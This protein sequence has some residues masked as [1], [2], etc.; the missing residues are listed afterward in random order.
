MPS[1][2]NGNVISNAALEAILEDVNLAMQQPRARDCGNIM[3]SVKQ[4]LNSHK[5]T[6]KQAFALQ[7]KREY[8][9]ERGFGFLETQTAPEAPKQEQPETEN[10]EP[11]P[12]QETKCVPVEYVNMNEPVPDPNTWWVVSWAED[13]ERSIGKRSLEE[14]HRRNLRTMQEPRTKYVRSNKEILWL[15]DI[16]HILQ[17]PIPET[18]WAWWGSLSAAD[19]EAANSRG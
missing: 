14:R 13:L 8:E 19:K 3:F 15:R 10:A 9:R 5:L 18:Y 4:R 7:F 2:D 12:S 11:E 17:E 6:L 16:A 1:D